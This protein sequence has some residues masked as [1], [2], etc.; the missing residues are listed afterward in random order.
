MEGPLGKAP[1]SQ[2]EP[3]SEKVS[4]E[5]AIEEERGLRETAEAKLQAEEGELQEATT[6]LKKNDATLNEARAK[7]RTAIADYKKST[8]F[9]NYIELKRQ[10]W[11][12][13]FQASPD[14]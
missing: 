5:L 11:L 10:K 2:R 9:N 1:N 7:I 13:N 4:L 6:E 8:V 14:Y 12:S 3:W